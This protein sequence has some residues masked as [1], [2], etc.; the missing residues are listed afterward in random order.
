MKSAKNIW[1]L[2]V[3]TLLI[4]TSAVFSQES[5]ETGKKG[6][7]VPV[8]DK[9]SEIKEVTRETTHEIM[10]GGRKIKYRAVAGTMV[11]KKKEKDPAASVFYIAYMKSDGKDPSKRPITFSFNGGPGSSSVWLHL[12]LLGPRRVLM[13]EDGW[14]YPPPYQ[15]VDNEYS[16]LDKTDLVFIDPVS[17]GYSRAVAGEDPKQFHGV[18]E[19]VKSVG[20]FIRIFLAR[21]ERWASPKFLIGESYGTT[22]AAGLSGYLQSEQGIFLNGIMLVS[23]ILNFQT[24]DF[25][26]GN[27]LPYILFLPT[28]TATAWYHGKLEA[29]LQQELSTALKEAEEFA[30]GEYSSVLLLGDAA[31][32]ERYD[33]AVKKLARL[34]GLSTDY[35]KQTNLRIR[36]WRFVKELLRDERRTTGRLDSRFTGIDSDAAGEG[37]QYDAS[38]ANIHGPFT[39]TL[40]DYVRRELEFESDLAYEIL[41]SNVRPWNYGKYKNRY[42][43][44]AGTLREA[45]TKNPDLKVFVAN[46]FYDLATPYFATVYTFEHLG[47]DPDLK[48]NVSMGFYEAGHMMY[49]HKQ[50]LVSL[51]SDL[52]RFI[53]SSLP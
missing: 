28:Y 26:P 13:K 53:E 14:A 45:M 38:Y 4:G 43:N 36:I 19:D 41:T 18:E 51:K 52:A 46:G 40:N 8:K 44:V 16:L 22:R 47:L 1:V 12:G 33:A 39:A 34:T 17:T 37:Y 50:S 31:P 6:M 21:N 42:I 9:K 2:A 29:D 27:D 3:I 48:G 7:P 25:H 15:L 5:K 20:E 11:L 23:S 35:I 24:A 10:I 32:E 49:I 30:L